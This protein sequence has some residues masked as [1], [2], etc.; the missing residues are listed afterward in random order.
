MTDANP[1][2]LFQKLYRV[3]IAPKQKK[4][5]LRNR[6]VVC[7]VVLAGTTLFAA[8]IFLLVLVSYLVLHN[9]YAAERLVSCGIAFAYLG[10][11]LALSRRKH[12]YA[13]SYLIIAFYGILAATTIWQWGINTPFGILVFGLVIVLAGILL[14]AR[15]ALYGALLGTLT[16]LLT[17]VSNIQGWHRPDTSWTTVDTNFGD[18]VAYSTGFAFLALISWLYGREMERSLFRAQQAEEELLK[19]KAMLEVRVKERTLE[20]R[21]AQL[22]E[23]QQ[24]YRFAE[25]G[26][27]STALLHDLANHLSVLTLEI[28]GLK[29]SKQHASA[30]SRSKDII[31]YMDNMVDDVRDQ[32]RGNVQNRSF[33]VMQKV[34]ETVELLRYKAAGSNVTLD[35]QL[36]SEKKQFTYIGDPVRLSQVIAIVVGNA[37]DAYDGITS[38]RADYSKRVT[39]RAKASRGQ[40]QI[41]IRDWGKGIPR[42]ER[43]HLFKPFQTTKKTGM[44]IGLFI[45]KQT[46]EAHFAGSI[47]L[48]DADDYTEFIITLAAPS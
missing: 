2:S 38:K 27:L 13:A 14:T 46:I 29:Q 16:L 20:L 3:F 39:V 47:T 24:M 4:P 45:A 28:D 43:K 32:L 44:G 33:N 8:I 22:E 41:Y 40:I 48:T 21:K 42:S 15:H 7:N 12:H 36:P 23:I 17:H 5:D 19:E 30:I 34:S 25:L 35:W 11:V 26:Q 1:G 18:V 31:H 6:E 37:I 10:G 9:D